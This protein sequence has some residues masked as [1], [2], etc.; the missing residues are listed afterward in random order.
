MAPPASSDWIVPALA[1]AVSFVFA[2][3]VARQWH[4]RRRPH[5]RAW[6]L[7]FVAYAAASALE[8]VAARDGWGV[9]AYKL[10]FPLAAAPV[11]LLGLGTVYL[12]R[13]GRWGH[14]FAAFVAVAILVAA[15]G[16]AVM[17]LREEATFDGASLGDSGPELGAKVVPYSN[18]GR[19][20]FLLLNVLGGLALIGG[21][22]ASWWSTRAPGVL[23]I[24]VGALLPAMGGA[25]AS[26]TGYD[27]RLMMQLL[28]VI[29]MFAGYLRSREVPPVAPARPTGEPS[30]P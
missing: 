5:Q 28:G 2:G 30:S 9:F 1:A 25:F 27:D 17:P 11:G 26:W 15:A 6:A 16:V 14:A 13:L 7:G 18:A 19:W 20:A 22:L 3:L 8:A 24:G 29:V 4:A 21:A 12:L 10:Y 23:L